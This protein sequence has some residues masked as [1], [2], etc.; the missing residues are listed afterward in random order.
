MRAAL[1]LLCGAS[2]PA[3]LCIH[4]AHVARERNAAQTTC[5]RALPARYILIENEIEHKV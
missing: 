1:R 4:V 5:T 2:V 3:S